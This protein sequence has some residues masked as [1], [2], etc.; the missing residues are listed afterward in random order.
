MKASEISDAIILSSEALKPAAVF[1][2]VLAD[3]SSSAAKMLLPK[4]ISPRQ[5]GALLAEINKHLAGMQDQLGA[6]KCR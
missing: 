3:D 6:P 2:W 5:L 1:V 4:S